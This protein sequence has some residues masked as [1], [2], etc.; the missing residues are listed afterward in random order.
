MQSSRVREKS[1]HAGEAAPL[2]IK[3][4]SNRLNPAGHTPVFGI[5]MVWHC[6][7]S[8]QALA[9]SSRTAIYLI[10]TPYFSRSDPESAL[11]L[12]PVFC[13]IDKGERLF[14]VPLGVVNILRDLAY[15]LLVELARSGEAIDHAA[16][17]SGGQQKQ[18]RDELSSRHAPPP[19]FIRH[20]PSTFSDS[21]QAP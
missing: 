1:T 12:Q 18:Q 11:F 3:K 9:R 8:P 5:W 7:F 19:A 16:Q 13:L 6:R 15:L 17:V 4:R 2:R 14:H 10:G 20:L 21:V